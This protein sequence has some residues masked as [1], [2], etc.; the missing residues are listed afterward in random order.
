MV[1]LS[2]YHLLEQKVDTSQR[3]T[4]AEMQKPNLHLLKQLQNKTKTTTSFH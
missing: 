1:I 2:F 3:F 4:K